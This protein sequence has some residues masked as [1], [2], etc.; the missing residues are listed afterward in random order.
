MI[1]FHEGLPR[2]GKSYEAMAVRIIPAIKAGRAVV[3]YVEGINHEQIAELAGVTVERCRELLHA[4]TREQI[5]TIHTDKNSGKVTRVEDHLPTLAVDNAMI[6]LDEAQNFWGNRAK[7]SADMTQFITEH[8]HRGIDLILMG[9]DLRD[10]H[11]VWRRRVELKLRFLK[12][13][14][15]SLHPKIAPFFGKLAKP[16]YSV[17][18]YRHTGGDDFKQV[19]TTLTVYDPKYFGTYKSFVADDTNTEVYTDKRAQVWSHPL[20]KYGMPL[21]L[22]GMIWGGL[23]AWKF[24]HPEKP[25][26]TQ[27][28]SKTA[29]MP[30]TGEPPQNAIQPTA[31]A[32]APTSIDQRTPIE[33]R[34]AELSTR[35]RIRLAGL[36][37]M[38]ERS[39]GI[40]EWVQAGNVVIER[41]TLDA[42]R[43]LGVGVVISGD[44]VT[45]AI[46]DFTD[47]A[48]PWPLEEPGRMSDAGQ[49]ALRGPQ[50][51]GAAAPMPDGLG[52]GTEPPRFKDLPGPLRQ[53]ETVG[54]V[55]RRAIRPEQ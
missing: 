21:M 41:L 36:A 5:Q 14:G 49:T 13:N 45:I 19:G 30:T 42:L 32:S 39:V 38:G 35:G 31:I 37:R 29:T 24:F 10:V 8:G 50:Q 11:A 2:S 40:V 54:T 12:L 47:L 55:F 28:E 7:L 20:M 27:A 22:A 9:Q 15:L 48:T 6:V 53:Q 43:T 34:M 33:K 51:L 1:I 18:T 44:V 25:K 17:T 26:E 16:S 23:T 46:G 52:T 3:A 4:I